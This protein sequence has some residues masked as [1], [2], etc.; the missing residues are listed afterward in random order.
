MSEWRSVTKADPCP[1]CER[2]DWC[3]FSGE[4]AV[5][6]YCMRAVDYAGS[7]WVECSSNGD[8]EGRLFKH[9]TAWTEAVRR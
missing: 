2:P 3:R 1:I 8:G 9:H 4:P 6:R 7:E 5:W